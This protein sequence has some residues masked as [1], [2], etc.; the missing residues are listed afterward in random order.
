[1]KNYSN[2]DTILMANTSLITTIVVAIQN[3]FILL[4]G[5]IE[6]VWF[7]KFINGRRVA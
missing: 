4:L 3:P 1:M 6:L 5:A 7:A 2:L